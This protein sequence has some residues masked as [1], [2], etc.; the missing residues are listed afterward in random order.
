MQRQEDVR[1]PLLARAAGEQWRRR[2]QRPA[3]EGPH[4]S[5]KGHMW[6]SLQRSW[7]LLKTALWE[8]TCSSLPFRKV[9]EAQVQSV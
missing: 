9:T 3:R 4:V 2:G 8:A 7:E 6:G 1:G 5:Y